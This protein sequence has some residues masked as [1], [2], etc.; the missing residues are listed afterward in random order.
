M[1]VVYVNRSW[2]YQIYIIINNYHGSNYYKG[3]GNINCRCII[4]ILINNG[5]E[6]IQ[7]KKYD[8]Y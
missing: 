4:L 7:N 3:P 5:I 6:N 2:N 1:V 8:K